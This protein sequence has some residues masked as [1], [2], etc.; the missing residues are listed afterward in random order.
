MSD[1]LRPMLNAPA[2]T[3]IA[4]GEEFEKD[5]IGRLDGAR[6]AR[7]SFKEELIGATKADPE[8]IERFEQEAFAAIE[9]MTGKL[10][11]RVTG[12]RIYSESEQA[13]RR[14]AEANASKRDTGITRR[15]R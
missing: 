2:E 12:K 9:S 11:D 10:F 5:K 13:A 8:S 3:G 6:A 15:R 1:E 14:E 4:A 7:E